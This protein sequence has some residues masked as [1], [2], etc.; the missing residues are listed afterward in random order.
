MLIL[1]SL[2]QISLLQP[3]GRVRKLSN[4]C[5]QPGWMQDLLPSG[6]LRAVPLLG[7]FQGVSLAADFLGTL[8]IMSILLAE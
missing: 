2:K 6:E 1:G 3:P 8:T 5:H 7:Q 4:N